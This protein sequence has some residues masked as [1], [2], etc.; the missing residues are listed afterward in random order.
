MGIDTVAV[1]SEPDAHAAFV[2]EADLAVPLGGAAPADSYLRG[3]PVA[4][5]RE[6]TIAAAL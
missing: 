5:E 6:N 1:Y 4:N 3:E 2:R